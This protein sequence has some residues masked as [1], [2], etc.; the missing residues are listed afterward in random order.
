MDIKIV[1]EVQLNWDITVYPSLDSMDPVSDKGTLSAQYHPATQATTG[2]L[3]E[4]LGE[5]KNEIEA[6]IQYKDGFSLLLIESEEGESTRGEKRGCRAVTLLHFL[7]AVPSGSQLK[8][9]KGEEK[10][11]R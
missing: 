11:E 2:F 4:L 6:P 8:G 10:R 9:K 1:P 7:R 3:Q 5:K